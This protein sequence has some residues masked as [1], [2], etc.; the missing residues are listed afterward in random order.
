MNKPMKKAISF[1]L[2][3]SIII[4][5]INLC[6]ILTSASQ[7][8][9]IKDPLSISGEVLTGEEQ[10]EK[11]ELQSESVEN[12]DVFETELEEIDEKAPLVQA[13][14]SEDINSL[15]ES[16]A[17]TT[18]IS[19]DLS[20]ENGQGVEKETEPEIVNTNE[21]IIENSGSE[22]NKK[23]EDEQI[24]D[25]EVSLEIQSIEQTED[26][27]VQTDGNFTHV[28]VFAK[29][30]DTA[31]TINTENLQML[32]C[33]FDGD[34][35]HQNA[36]KPYFERISNGHLQMDNI[37]PQYDG[38]QIVPYTLNGNAEDYARTENLVRATV[39][40]LTENGKISEEY[41]QDGDGLWDY[42]TIV[43]PGTGEYVWA[44]KGLE[45]IGIGLYQI[46]YADSLMEEYA[47]PEK[48]LKNVLRSFGYPDIQMDEAE[49]EVP[50]PLAF[51]RS[52]ISGWLSVPEVTE[53]CIGYTL[54]DIYDDSND[55][56]QAVILKTSASDSEVFVVEY[57]H[58]YLS[59]GGIVVYRVSKTEAVEENNIL[60]DVYVFAPDE[61]ITYT[62]GSN[63]GITLE[64]IENL[65]EGQVIF[66]ISFS[67][68]D[69]QVSLT[70][71]NRMIAS[72]SLFPTVYEGVDYSPVF[73]AQ[74]Y[75]NS[76]KDLKAK[77]R[78]DEDKAFS[79]F[80]E[81]GMT[82]G[83]QGCE[84]FNVYTYKNRYS[85]LRAAFG[86]DLKQYYLH[87]LNT[88]MAEGRSGEGTSSFLDPITVYE[89][90]D[91][92]PVYNYDYYLSTYED[93]RQ[94]YE[95]DDTGAL[96]HFVHSGMSEGRQ[97]NGLFNVQTYRNRYADLRK[98]FGNNLREY[99]IHYLSS[100]ISE[101]RSGEGIS[102]VVNAETVYNGIDYAAVYDYNYYI[103]AYDDL[104]AVFGGDEMKTL[105]HFVQNGMSEGRQGIETFNVYT[106]KNRYS[107]L[108]KVFGNDLR[109]YYLHFINNGLREGRS[110]EGISKVNNPITVYE[111]VDYSPVYDYYYYVD[112]YSDVKDT[113]G[114][115][116]MSVLQ[117]FVQ[118]GMS[119][120]RQGNASFNVYAYRERY[121]DLREIYG[122][123]MKQYYLHYLSYGIYEG[124]DGSG[125]TESEHLEFYPGVLLQQINCAVLSYDGNSIIVTIRTNRDS[126]LESMDG[127]LGIAMLNSSGTDLLEWTEG[128]ATKSG[129][130]TVNAE[131]F[132][133]DSFRTEAMG[134][135]AIAVKNGSS[136]IVI[137]DSMYLSNPDIFA[138]KEESFKDK[139]MGYYEGY[140]ITSKKGIQGVSMSYT[141][142]L[143]VQHVLLNVDIADMVSTSPAAGYVSYVYKG[144]TYYFQDLIAL[145]DTIYDLHGWGSTD[146]NAYGENHT[147]AVT[148][149]LLLS[150][151]DSLSYLIHPSARSKGAA[152]YYALNMAEEC[153][154]NTFEALFCYMGE[155]LG[156]YKERVTNWTLGNEVNSCRAWNYS[157][158]MSLEECVENYAE[159]FQLLYQGVKRTAGSSRIFISLDHCWTAADAGH[160]GKA[161]LDAFAS[162]MNK[163]APSMQWN[164]NYHPYSQPLSR[165][166]FWNDY[167][168]TTDAAD[169]RYISMRNI[170]ILTD[171]LGTLETQYGKGSGSIRVI[172]GELGFSAA[173][174]NS[175]QENE[176]A[177]ALG[178]GYYKAMFNTR[179]DAYII[180]AYLDDPA[181]T[182]AGLHLGLRRNDGSQTAKIS[183]DV[184]QNLDTDQ[185]LNYMNQYL[186]VIGI[187]S[188]ESAISGF[189]ASELAAS[190]F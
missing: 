14:N 71:Q 152:S 189:D 92:S 149:N 50:N 8:D 190:D 110:G 109:Q 116:D 48:L 131:F 173:G 123:D 59:E 186:G 103:N 147:R 104:K 36:M 3:V 56:N 139:Y 5:E 57:S 137:S 42:L 167:S 114:N 13:E 63:S 31:N 107:D 30:N 117:H 143:R 129:K 90:V 141:E 176:Q 28:I 43:L 180:R 40:Q 68:P 155:E 65:E 33:L 126:A 156:Q 178:Y 27:L 140:K 10:A 7:I 158:S 102:I 67:H 32:Q 86:N 83:R 51:F 84:N 168:N 55:H 127:I 187:G 153:A 108:R 16:E 39:Q 37:Y 53:S 118:C 188:W 58:M 165:N 182:S 87:Y 54:Y 62:D 80:L 170:Q 160:S 61:M 64:N 38:A 74:Y 175:G 115:D 47:N 133:N 124:R 106:Y 93:L 179:I 146:G 105:E 142:D 24:D 88:G 22:E 185:S 100:G 69:G 121:A 161:Y 120:G 15:E 98:A 89:G 150:W 164:V 99:Y 25:A 97:G 166:D 144:Q 163:T 78:N 134:K 135:Y 162:Y 96:E 44:D 26:F 111:G 154:R 41:D 1:L 136:V 177:A 183:Y 95:G 72:Q 113:F 85:D 81:T 6:S 66:D 76:Y 184:Y 46:A 82:E 52:E 18:V 181:E 23:V 138:S 172:I 11:E 171:Y 9:D 60:W 130:L 94:I 151:D 119:E 75:L 148:L 34:E 122:S 19:P 101:G 49:S 79:H 125:D 35:E 128:A 20:D 174:G 91:Y 112:K 159:A 157:G 169:T 12:L 70:A 73:D 77:F 45:D 17:A 132:S 29:F 4:T 2:L 145:K 21:N